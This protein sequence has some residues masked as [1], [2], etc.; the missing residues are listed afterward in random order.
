MGEGKDA[1]AVLGTLVGTG[2]TPCTAKG[3]EARVRA[4]RSNRVLDSFLAAPMLFRISDFGTSRFTPAIACLEGAR[5]FGDRTY[6]L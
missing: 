2:T 5:L 4:C 6:P 3:K 1:S